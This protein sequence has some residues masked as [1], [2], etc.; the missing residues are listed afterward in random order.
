MPSRWNGIPLAGLNSSALCS[1]SATAANRKKSASITRCG[2]GASRSIR[3]IGPWRPSACRA[4]AAPYS[5][6]RC[7][8]T[9]N[10][11]RRSGVW[12]CRPDGSQPAFLSVDNEKDLMLETTLTAKSS[13]GCVLVAPQKVNDLP[14]RMASVLPASSLLLKRDPGVP[15]VYLG[16]AVLMVG[17]G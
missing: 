17:G 10:W 16:F 3:P 2:T 7:R 15:L 1:R 13:P 14:L 11:E 6:Y 4:A 8:P 12:C 9:R 5:N